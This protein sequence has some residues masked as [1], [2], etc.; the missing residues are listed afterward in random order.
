MAEVNLET[1]TPAERAYFDSRGEKPIE[2][3]A[4]EDTEAVDDSSDEA[5]VEAPEV[6]AKEEA[7]TED[8][9]TE[10]PEKPKD[11]KVSYNSLHAE[12]E[13]R[14]ELERKNA[15]L[16]EQFARADERLRMLFQAQQPEQPRQPTVPDPKD[17][18]IGFMEWQKGEVERLA[19]EQRQQ[20]EAYQQQAQ[21]NAIDTA[22]K[23]SWAVFNTERPDA[24]D[25]YQHFVNVTAAYLEMQG[26]PQQQI[27]DLVQN[28]ERKITVAAMQR[29]MNPAELIYEKAKT[30]GYMP[31][32]A[33]E[34]ETARK[35]EAD[36]DRRQK[37]AVASKSLSSAGG[38]KANTPSAMDLAS[39]SDE[40]FEEFRARNPRAYKQI[41]G[42]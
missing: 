14:K 31:K 35:A 34:A 6:E 32:A 12:R 11:K 23:Q 42:G 27:N 4:P 30:F 7:E 33:P 40:E 26:V 21:I 13:R 22:Y 17:D 39:M 29:G 37:A 2:N 20:Q 16:Q 5:E 1:F 28:E 19:S 25:A 36:I 15:E 9:E 3:E 10:K 24:L 41:M 18:P 38:T 8:A